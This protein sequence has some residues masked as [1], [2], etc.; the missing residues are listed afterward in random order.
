MKNDNSLQGVEHLPDKYDYGIDPLIPS[1]FKLDEAVRENPL[2]KYA[3]E[4]E[5]TTS[6]VGDLLELEN[7]FAT[8]RRSIKSVIEQ[9]NDVLKDAIVL[10]SA[11]DSPRTIEVV[12]NL[13]KTI[14]DVNKDLLDLHDKRETIKKKRNAR[15]TG[16]NPGGGVVN[17]QNNYFMSSPKDLIESLRGPDDIDE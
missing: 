12:A 2:I 4:E 8:A 11:S 9:S 16:E 13:L 5:E 6:Q 10:A 1:T 14:A 3:E 17:Q 7:D 15:M